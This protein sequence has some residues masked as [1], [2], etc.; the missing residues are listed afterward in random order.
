MK[1]SRT[2]RLP[3][4]WEI[5]HGNAIRNQDDQVPPWAWGKYHVLD[6][7]TDHIASGA[8]PEEAAAKAKALYGT[9]KRSSSDI[10]G[11]KFNT[12]KRVD[13]GEGEGWTPARRARSNNR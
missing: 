12:P 3:S 4:N 2:V 8:T 13:M 9:P 11:L 10:G 7:R 1:G 6:S 5:R